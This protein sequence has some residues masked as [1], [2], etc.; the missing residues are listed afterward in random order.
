[1]AECRLNPQTGGPLGEDLKAVLAVITAN[2]C[3]RTA[4]ELR[5]YYKVARAFPPGVRCMEISWACHLEAR[6][7]E[8][9]ALILK[10]LGPAAD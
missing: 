4:H 8:T 3:E 2:G 9:L 7:Q 1:M 10:S 6:D 5:Q